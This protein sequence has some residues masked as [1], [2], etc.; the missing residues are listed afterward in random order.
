MIQWNIVVHAREVV[1]PKAT[2]GL[3]FGQPPTRSADLRVPAGEKTGGP[4][5]CFA[6]GPLFCCSHHDRAPRILF[7]SQSPFSRVVAAGLGSLLLWA[8][9]SKLLDMQAFVV[10]IGDFGLVWE[11]FLPAVAW[12]VVGIEFVL[13]GG[14][15][16]GRRWPIWGAGGL[17]AVFLCVLGYGI[18]LDLDIE[19]GCFGTGG[20]A[21]GLT[22]K[23]AAGLDV[24]LLATCV[25]LEWSRRSRMNEPPVPVV[26]EMN[27]GET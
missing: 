15:W 17:M 5:A 22:L 11:P 3:S 12:C 8:G 20:E 13:G 2:G 18:L 21:A 25:W 16:T 26:S 9:A 10:A 14:L 24:L 19:C 7:M 23:Q 1:T 4:V 6:A 27:N